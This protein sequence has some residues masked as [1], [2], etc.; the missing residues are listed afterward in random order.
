[1]KRLLTKLCHTFELG[2]HEYIRWTLNGP[3][4]LRFWLTVLEE[5]RRQGWRRFFYWRVRTAIASTVLRR[6]YS[7]CVVCQKGYTFRDLLW[8]DLVHYQSGTVNHGPCVRS[9][10]GGTS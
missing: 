9:P 3:Y 1:M 4:P 7:R 2:D 5:R 6:M 10:Q 8:G